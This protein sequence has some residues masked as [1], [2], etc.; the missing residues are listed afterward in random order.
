MGEPER[1]PTPQIEKEL[2]LAVDGTVTMA[3]PN[4]MFELQLETGQR[5]IGYVAGRMRRYRVRIVP[6]DRV[7]VELSPY[8]LSR[9]RIVYRYATPAPAA[10]V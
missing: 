7:R 1:A 8:D 3:L 4:A 2:P 6:G 9:G 10:G 5:V